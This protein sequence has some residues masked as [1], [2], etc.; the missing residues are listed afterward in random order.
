MKAI[1]YYEYG[2]AEV[3]RLVEI[4]KPTPKDNEILVKVRAAALNPADRHLMKGS[5]PIIRKLFKL[6]TVTATEPGR[7]GRDVAGEVEAVG[8]DVIEFKPGDAV[9]G[10]TVGACSEYVCGNESR[11]VSKPDNVSFEEAASAPVAAFTA[12]QG[13][14]DKGHI[15]AGY[16]VLING[17]SG[18][19][20]TYAV[21]IAKS[22]GAEVTG[23]CSTRNVELVRSIGADHVIDYA[24]E[25]FTNSGC[26]YDLVFDCVW[27]HSLS[28]CKRILKAQGVYVIAGG[29][30][31]KGAMR[32]LARVAKVSLA[33]RFSRQKFMLFMAKASKEDLTIT[34]E[35]LENRKLKPIIDRCYSLAETPAAM[36]YLDEGHA[37]GKIVITVA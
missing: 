30:V 34:R 15:Q 37:R 24:Q 9:F 29:P 2:S 28:Q 36:R 13:L 14:R 6:P 7:T 21:Q 31:S 33:S 8:K 3:L 20:G 23:V 19:V 1:V 10:S 32:F 16:K 35:L 5:S 11:F 4:E 12:L 26:L 17:A 18:G 22:F 25:D 27:T